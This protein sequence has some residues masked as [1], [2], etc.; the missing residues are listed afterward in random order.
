MP[1]IFDT[2]PVEVRQTLDIALPRLAPRL[3]VQ[4]PA[5]GPL[6]R[7]GLADRA[8]HIARGVTGFLAAGRDQAPVAVPVHVVGLDTLA[9]DAGAAGGAVRA[10]SARLWTNLLTDEGGRTAALAD[11]EPASRTLAA[12]TEGPTITAMGARLDSLAAE[13]HD[14][15]DRSVAMLRVPALHLTALWLKGATA[16][17]DVVIPNPGPIAPLQAGR[18][19]SMAEFLAIV[20]PMAADRIRQ[21]QP[22]S[23]G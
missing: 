8:P 3:A 11:V 1:L 13:E 16:A 20:Q 17:D 21:T 2:P 5:A 9:Q 23:G 14:G 18:R 12:L 15:P 22:T 4:P 7:T 6:G 10:T 19:Y